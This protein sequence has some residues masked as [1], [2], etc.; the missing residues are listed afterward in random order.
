MYYIAETERLITDG[1]ISEGQANEIKSRAR[2]V[3]IAL[4]VNALLVSGIIAAT[5]GLVLYLGSALSVAI[6]GGLFLAVGLL[7]LLYATALYR[8]FGNA[9]FLIGAGML[10]TGS[11]IELADKIPDAA[12]W[13]MS[14]AGAAIVGLCT[15]RFRAVPSH[16]R[17]AIG[18]LLLMGGGLHVVGFYSIFNHADIRGWAA[19]FVHFYVFLFVAALGTLLDVRLITA[20]AIVPFAQMLDTGTY[21]FSA[22]YVFYSPEPTLSILQMSWLIG[23][24][25]WASNRWAGHVS[26]QTGILMIMAFVVANLCFLVGSIWGD[27]VG[28][29]MW[30]PTRNDFDDYSAYSTARDIFRQSAIRISEHVYAVIWAAL[31]AILIVW[32][33]MSNRRGL[34]NTGM[35]FAAIHGYT[36]MFESFF[37]EPLAYAIGGLIAIPLAFGLWRLN[38]AWFRPLDVAGAR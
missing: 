2:T 4:G 21:Y 26:R 32:T 16:L 27:V 30:A 15:W 10:I 6:C 29:A 25:L 22:A 33:A 18:A 8:M 35:T 14:V 17:F 7:I 24:C 23:A 1:V 11:G 20:L 5:V 12:G 28:D 13:L 37:D 31:L 34:F 3:M 9:S 19:P 36:Q 38:N